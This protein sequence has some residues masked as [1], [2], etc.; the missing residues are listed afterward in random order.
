[1][2]WAGLDCRCRAIRSDKLSRNRLLTTVRYTHERF[3]R[4]ALEIVAACVV[5]VRCWKFAFC[6]TL[7]LPFLFQGIAYSPLLGSWLARSLGNVLCGVELLV[8]SVWAV[9][10]LSW[11]S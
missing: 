11:E 5:S 9:L 6:D 4:N 8:V 1:M 3:V 2:S 10:G 7:A